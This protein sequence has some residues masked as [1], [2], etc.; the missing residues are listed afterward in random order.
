MLVI[1]MRLLV[2]NLHLLKIDADIEIAILIFVILVILIAIL[3]LSIIKKAG[4]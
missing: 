1:F 2:D 3:I 4:K